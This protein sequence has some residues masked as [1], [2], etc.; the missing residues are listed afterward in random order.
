MM[1]N[2]TLTFESISFSFGRPARPADERLKIWDEG[3]DE[4]RAS[5]QIQVAFGLAPP[6]I[7]VKVEEQVNGA[8]H[9]GNGSSNGHTE[10][11]NGVK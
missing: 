5:E 6:V 2:I 10:N 7:E 9:T 4:L 8:A 3:T 1:R 11:G